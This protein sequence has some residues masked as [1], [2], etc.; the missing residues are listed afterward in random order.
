MAVGGASGAVGGAK[1]TAAT[2]AVRVSNPVDNISATEHLK[3]KE[4]VPET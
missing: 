2:A 1:S 4:T 3:R